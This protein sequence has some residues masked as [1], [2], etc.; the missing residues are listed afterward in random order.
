MR[1]IVIL[2][3]YGVNPGDMSWGPI[4]KFGVVTVYERTAVSEILPRCKGAE[5]I[6]TNKVPFNAATIAGLDSCK[7]IGVL[8]TGYNLIDLEVA[9]SK[10]IKVTN[11]PAY[12]TDSVA[13]NVFAL[14]LAITNHAEEYGRR[15][16]DGKWSRCKDFSY[17]DFPLMELSGKRMG[18]IGYGHIG[19]AVAR[20]ARA[21]GMNVGVYSSRSQNELSEVR[22]MTL[23][24]LFSE[25]DVV[26]LHCPLTP[27]T[28]HLVNKER[29]AMMKSTA[30]L[31][32]TGRGPLVD[33]ESLADALNSGAIYA[34][35][36]DVLS[37]EP[38]MPDNPLLTAKN[39]I[40]TPHISWA[41][42]EARQ[43]LMDIAAANIEAFLAGSPVNVVNDL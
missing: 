11:I 8:A 38:P 36:L 33:E 35:G 5:I 6:L 3:G 24:E 15:N 7:Y 9:K 32:N 21:F 23:D 16:R 34:A 20:I 4:E 42:R 12:S 17:L 29:L 31:I 2:D 28:Y 37:A 10:G 13:Q 14:L 22:K 19:Q 43:R 40:I 41:S 26:S 1:R 18:I 39:C 27:D 30:I 25:C